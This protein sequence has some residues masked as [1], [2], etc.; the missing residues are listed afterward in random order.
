MIVKQ[1]IHAPADLK[2]QNTRGK[3]T[4]PLCRTLQ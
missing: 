1:I 4:P 2:Q 3:A